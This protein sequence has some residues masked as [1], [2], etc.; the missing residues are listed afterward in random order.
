MPCR[1]SQLEGRWFTSIPCFSTPFIPRTARTGAAGTLCILVPVSFLPYLSRVLRLQERY[2]PHQ[3]ISLAESRAFL[4]RVHTGNLH[5]VG[6]SLAS[7]PVARGSRG[8]GT[9][10]RRRPHVPAMGPRGGSSVSGTDETG[11]LLST[12]DETFS[13]TMELR[14]LGCGPHLP[15]I[16]RW[17]TRGTGNGALSH[18]HRARSAGPAWQTGRHL[19]PEGGSRNPFRS[20]TR[21]SLDRT[22]GPTGPSRANSP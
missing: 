4:G 15:G 17:R 22:S 13:L 6:N 11:G 5:R 16:A 21:A 14:P 3:P 20:A 7:A 2:H 10:S 8:N 1:R 18:H 19:R 12:S 9:G